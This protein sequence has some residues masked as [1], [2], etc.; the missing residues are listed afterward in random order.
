MEAP[1]AAQEDYDDDD[2]YDDDYDDEY[3]APEDEQPS[4]GFK[5]ADEERADLLNK[6]KRLESKGFSVNKRLNAHSSV[7]DLRNEV[8]RI[9]YSIDVDQ[10]VK[11]S[12]RALIAA[13]PRARVFKQAIQSV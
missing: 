3:D 11:F 5:N 12:R 2:E 4:A 7:D 10:S 9:T 13:R 6:L 1:T 8:K